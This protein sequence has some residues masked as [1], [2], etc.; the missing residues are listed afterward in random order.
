MGTTRCEINLNFD[1]CYKGNAIVNNRRI[2]SHP[3]PAVPSPPRICN[4]S[5]RGWPWL[6]SSRPWTPDL[7][8]IIPAGAAMG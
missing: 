5:R 2:D 1:L 7:G 8:S 3:Q 4:H 6:A